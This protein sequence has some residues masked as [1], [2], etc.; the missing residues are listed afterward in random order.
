M[1]D[2][3]LAKEQREADVRAIMALPAGRRFVF[4]LLER[5]GLWDSS[6]SNDAPSM[7]YAEGRRSSAINLMLELQHV[8]KAGYVLMMHEAFDAVLEK[9]EG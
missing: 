1:R 2:E 5:N 3:A 4:G 6:F 9:D 8:D 7:A